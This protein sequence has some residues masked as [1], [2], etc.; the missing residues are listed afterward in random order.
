MTS[1]HTCHPDTLSKDVQDKRIRNEE[2]IQAA[3]EGACPAH[4]EIMEHSCCEQRKPVPNK[5]HIKLFPA[6][7][8]AAYFRYACARLIKILL[9]IKQPLIAKSIEAIVG[10]IQW[11]EARLP[12]QPNQKM[13]I[14][15]KIAP[16][17]AGGSWYSGLIFQFPL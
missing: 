5:D 8:E 6:R 12:V 7:E 4:S 1:I 10:M 16:T 11:T 2:H 15:S 3:Q 14:G 17:Q 9:K 13:E